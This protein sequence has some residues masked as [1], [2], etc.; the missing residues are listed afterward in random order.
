[1]SLPFLRSGVF[2]AQN[3]ITIPHAKLIRSLGVLSATQFAV[4]ERAVRLWLGLPT[5]ESKA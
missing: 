4:V 5:T 1:V 2:D 3:L